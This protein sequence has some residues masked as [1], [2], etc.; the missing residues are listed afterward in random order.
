[1]LGRDRKNLGRIVPLC[2]DSPWFDA[3]W[4]EGVPFPPGGDTSLMRTC[5]CCHRFYP[6]QYL[7]SSGAC[8]ECAHDAMT[9][10]QLRNLVSSPGV[11][12]MARLKAAI[13]VGRQYP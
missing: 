3:R 5:N 1:M 6:P 13:R 9:P 11:I 12:D 10:M 4:H 8:Q 2:P 7:T